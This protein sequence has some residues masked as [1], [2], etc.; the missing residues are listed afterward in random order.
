M[1]KDSKGR[2]FCVQR[3]PAPF[4]SFFIKNIPRP[5]YILFYICYTIFMKYD[6]AT[7]YNKNAAF[8]YSRPKAKRAVLVYNQYAPYFF[9]IAYALLWVFGA[10]KLKFEA[11][12]FVKIFCA[13]AFALLLVSTLRLAISRPRP[14]EEEGSQIVPLQEKASKGNTFPSRH[15]TCAAVIATAFLPYLPAF[16]ALLLCMSLALG[17]TRFAIGWHYPSDLVA[18]FLLGLV[19]GMIPIL[20]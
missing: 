18:G 7:L 1:E 15:L 19:I 6:Y 16:G 14:Y 5:L 8:L 13:P 4:L 17:Y 20:L 11:V 12:D 10:W 9:L 3:I 2:F